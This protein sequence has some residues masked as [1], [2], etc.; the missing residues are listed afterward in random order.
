MLPKG[1]FDTLKAVEVRQHFAHG[2]R[3]GEDVVNTTC[4]DPSYDR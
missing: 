2:I 3:H 4:L 1:R